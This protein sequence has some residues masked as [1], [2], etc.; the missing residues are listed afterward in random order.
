MNYSSFNSVIETILFKF[1]NQGHLGANVNSI[2]SK[3]KSSKDHAFSFELLFLYINLI[4]VL[5]YFSFVIT[6]RKM[7]YID[8]LLHNLN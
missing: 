1:G 7:C 3:L 6:K 4:L 8:F 2:H 5:I